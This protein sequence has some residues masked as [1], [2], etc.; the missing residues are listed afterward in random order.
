MLARGA[1]DRRRRSFWTHVACWT[2][3]ALAWRLLPALC[4]EVLAGARARCTRLAVPVFEMA[5]A[6]QMV[7]VFILSCRTFGPLGTFSIQLPV[8]SGALLGCVLALSAR[9]ARGTGV[10]AVGGGGSFSRNVLPV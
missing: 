7:W 2:F 5:G 1:W 4:L 8:V 6:W 10:N 9:G 3:A